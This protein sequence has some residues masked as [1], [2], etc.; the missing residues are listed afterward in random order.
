VG[1]SVNDCE[2]AP[3]T[4]VQRNTL[5]ALSCLVDGSEY[6]PDPDPEFELPSPRRRDYSRDILGSNIASRF[7]GK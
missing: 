3:L 6:I 1:D 7:G 5:R 4:H 2:T